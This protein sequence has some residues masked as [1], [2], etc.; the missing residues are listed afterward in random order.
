[1]VVGRV[2]GTSSI[3]FAIGRKI[4]GI[5]WS[6]E[7]V[8][9]WIMASSLKK[10]LFTF[11]QT[12]CDTKPSW[13]RILNPF[14]VLYLLYYGVDKECLK[15]KSLGV[16]FSLYVVKKLSPHCGSI[17]LQHTKTSK[18]KISWYILYPFNLDFNWYKWY[19]MYFMSLLIT[20]IILLSKQ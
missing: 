15:I 16:Y 18:L 1:M 17:I 7:H 4:P 6:L 12:H 13:I 9:P 10:I 2:E 11:Y 20:L 19:W 14:S 3:L 5:I 8:L